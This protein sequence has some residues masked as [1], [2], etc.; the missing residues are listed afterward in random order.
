MEFIPVVDTDRIS[1]DILAQENVDLLLRIKEAMALGATAAVVEKWAR[2]QFANSTTRDMVIGAA[3]YIERAGRVEEDT[4][5]CE[6]STSRR[7]CEWCG[8]RVEI[9]SDYKRCLNCGRHQ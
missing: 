3:H 7:N 9:G 1:Y 2:L 5:S 8:G 6:V 4:A